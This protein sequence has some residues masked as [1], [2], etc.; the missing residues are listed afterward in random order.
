MSAENPPL[1]LD[2]RQVRR[3]FERAAATSDPAAAVQREV[4]ARMAER[5]GIVKLAPAAILDA[6]CGTGEA[7]G[8]LRTRYPSAQIT[9][10]DFALAMVRA[11]R[12]RAA[13]AAVDGRSLLARITGAH[14]GATSPAPSMICGA[15]EALPLESSCTDLI[16]SN[17]ALQWID[18]PKQ[19]FAEFHRVL[20][21]GGLLTF[22]TLG[23]DTLRELRTAFAG[24]DSATHVHHFF[25]MHDVG[26]MLV[27]SGFAD[28]VMNM[29]MLTLT[30]ENATALIH[31]LR[32]LGAHNATVGRPRGLT[33][34]V[35]WTR[36][37]AALERHRGDG[38]L[39]VTIEVIYG[40]A[41][42]PEPRVVP[43]GRSIVR[44]DL[45]RRR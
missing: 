8:E 15:L 36:M 23:P 27:E 1:A 21:V 44:F 17:L 38:R 9:G 16:W 35:R 4:G 39:A 41:W 13:R 43:D 26:D 40:H 20:R 25:D 7:L 5:L 18:A 31:E 32:A 33:G 28:P 29:E 22:T 42:K 14:K 34:R 45:P 10:I 3:A 11:A 37:L 30:Y 2:R 12:E 24:I 6:G 19:A